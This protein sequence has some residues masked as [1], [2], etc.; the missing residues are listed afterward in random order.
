MFVRISRC[1]LE[2][3]IFL[4]SA[5][6]I[7]SA[8]RG[9]PGRIGKSHSSSLLNDP[10]DE[11]YEY[12][13]KQ[14]FNNVSPRHN[15]HWMKMNKKRTSSTSSQMTAYSVDTSASMELRGSQTMSSYNSDSEQQGSNDVKYE[16]MDIRS[17]DKDD[18]PP[19]HAPPLPPLLVKAMVDG[20]VE[21]VEDEEVD[22]YVEDSTYHYTN[23]QPKL[24]QALKQMKA[25]KMQRQGKGQ[26]YEYEDMDSIAS[27][28]P[29]DAAVYQNIQKEGEGAV[30]KSPA[31][32]SGFDTY[33]RVR[34]GVGMGEP[35]AVDRSFDNPDYWHSRMFLK[36][37]AVPT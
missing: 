3:N 28:R 7:L 37:N 24:R 13:N 27:A 36:A 16:Y 15:G 23:R 31:Q 33:V 17:I 32:Q 21:E 6:T 29:E 5:D 19:A 18:S 12:M 20:E 22:G 9:I 11:E 8:S 25:V 10:D 14:I 1:C 30:G 34:A 35:T 26:L 2:F 4:L